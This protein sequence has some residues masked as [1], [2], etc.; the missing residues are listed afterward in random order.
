M[1]ELPRIALFDPVQHGIL[2]RIVAR[3]RFLPSSPRP[4]DGVSPRGPV[5]RPPFA[6]ARW[7][8]TA[9]RQFEM[10]RLLG[11]CS[12]GLLAID[13]FALHRCRGIP[14]FSVD[15]PAAAQMADYFFELGYRSF[16]YC[17][18]KGV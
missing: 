16:A 2:A 15:H 4:L 9:S 17:G 12:A 13:L 10:R 5:A 11:R 7:R 8:R 18:F 3:D 6:P 1:P 14:R